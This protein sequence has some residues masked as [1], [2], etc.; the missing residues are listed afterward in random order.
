[1]ENYTAHLDTF[2]RDNLPAQEQQAETIFTLDALQFPKKLNCATELL[3]KAVQQG[4]GDRIALRSEHESWSYR[5]LLEKANQIAHVLVDDFKLIPGNRVLLRSANKPML[6]AC[7]LAVAKAGGIVVATMPLLRAHD[8][9]PI[10]CKARIQLSLC[11]EQLKDEL[12]KAIGSDGG[13][14]CFFNASSEM[15]DHSQL[16]ARMADKP[17]SFD[18]VQTASDDIALIAFTSGTTGEPKGAMH[19]HKDVMAMCV[20]VCDELL[21]AGANDI[22]IG[23]PPIAFAFG[24]GMQLAFPLYAG[25]SC[26]LLEA[27]SPLILAESI[28]RFKATICSTAPTAYQAILNLNEQYDLSSL[29]KPVSAGEHLPLPIYERWLEKTGVKI[30]DGLGATE[31]IHIFVSATGDDIRPGSTGKAVPGYTLCILD[32][33]NKILPAGSKGRLAAKGPTACKYLADERQKNYVADGWNISGDICHMDEDGY[34]WYHGRSDDMII[35]AG[36]N[37]SGP[38]VE[39]ALLA[40]AS[41]AEC[42]VVAA[43]DQERGTIVKAFVVLNDNYTGTDTLVEELQTFVKQSIA[44]YKYPRAVEFISALPKTHTGKIQRNKL[45]Q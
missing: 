5:E 14:V 39:T 44:P 19:F 22:F 12:V 8:L 30:I 18:N 9:K 4:N 20:C 3:D 32:E 7:W 38:E 21:K 34:V 41:V 27:A 11:D 1:M 31:M 26:V 25:A 13:T 10:L 24:L 15:G 45:R 43:S 42:A 6:A 16:G 35:S 2:A 40:H 36:Y 37:I 33:D 28:E 17:T 23:T 29:K